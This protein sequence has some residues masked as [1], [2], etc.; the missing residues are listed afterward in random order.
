MLGIFLGVFYCYMPIEAYRTARAK[1]MG[2]PVTGFF[3]ETAAP[4][5]PTG[6]ATGA[7]AAQ[8]HRNY[9]GSIVIIVIGVICLLATTDVLNSR[10]IEYLWPLVIVAVGVALLFK[11]R[12]AT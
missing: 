9:T 2:L 5:P 7:Q 10:W 4:V 12:I 1:R 3:G 11:R 8:V 6:D